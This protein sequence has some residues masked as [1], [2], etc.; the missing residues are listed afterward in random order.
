ML[1]TIRIY[2]SD[3]CFVVCPMLTKIKKSKELAWNP[4]Y[5][6]RIWNTTAKKLRILKIDAIIPLEKIYTES[7]IIIKTLCRKY[8]VRHGRMFVKYF[9]YNCLRLVRHWGFPLQDCCQNHSPLSLLYLFILK[10]QCTVDVLML[11]W[12]PR[13]TT[14]GGKRMKLNFVEHLE[15]QALW[16]IKCFNSH[17][18]I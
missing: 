16:G 4:N 10:C 3:Y 5:Y 9:G 7:K 6:F 1:H 15:N 12:F 17:K 8:T 14:Q 11:S 2:T 13:T 18:T